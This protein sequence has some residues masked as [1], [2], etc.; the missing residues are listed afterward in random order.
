MK[1]V[2]LCPSITESLVALGL[3]EALAGVTRFCVHP[4][5]ELNAV[6]R[7]GGTKDPDVAAILALAPD[8]VFAN[9]EENRREDVEALVEKVPVDLSHPRSPDEVPALLRRWGARTGAD[10]SAEELAGVI[11]RRIAGRRHAEEPF[12][13]VVLIWKD[14]WMATS[15]RTYIDGVLRGAGGVPAIARPGGTDYPVVTEA[16]IV[17]AAPDLLILPDE[18]F[19][20]GERHRARFVALMPDADVRC[21]AGDDLC[22]HGVRTLRG[23]EL[24]D[25]LV[26]SLHPAARRA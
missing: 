17:A 24:A 8:L 1:L 7:I 4:A 14:P 5:D 25:D 6:P 13:Y 20:F 16:E 2:S 21:V 18:P 12:R 3:R 22:W 23:L 19:R 26:A 10:A 9:G 15:G 11:E